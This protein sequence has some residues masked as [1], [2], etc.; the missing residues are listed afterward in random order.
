MASGR[1]DEMQCPGQQ[2]SVLQ[3][4]DNVTQKIADVTAELDDAKANDARK[5]ELTR[6]ESACEASFAFAIQSIPNPNFS[7]GKQVNDS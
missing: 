4:M 6:L 5:A 1:E 2:I 7:P 3:N